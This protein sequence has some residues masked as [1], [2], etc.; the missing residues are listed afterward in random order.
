MQYYNDTWTLDDNFG[1]GR[2]G[3]QVARIAL[4]AE[5]PFT[6]GITGKWGSGKTSVMRRAFVTLGGKP[7]EQKLPMQDALG[8]EKN[9]D[10]KALVYSETE[11][12]R[13][14]LDWP[15]KVHESTQQVLCVWYSPW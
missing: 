15:K 5:P 11:T 2:A 9:D 1:M 13:L 10:W 4:E 3:D 12:R 8:R 6:L 7:V 14:Q